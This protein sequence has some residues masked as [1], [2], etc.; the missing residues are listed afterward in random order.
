MK[1]AFR[2]LLLFP[3]G[4]PKFSNK[5]FFKGEFSQ[6]D[7]LS[8]PSNN[9]CQ[10]HFRCSTARW[11]EVGA[12]YEELKDEKNDWSWRRPD[13][14]RQLSSGLSTMERLGGRNKNILQ[15]CDHPGK[16]T[17]L[18]LPLSCQALE[19]RKGS[20]VTWHQ[21]EQCFQLY[22]S[23]RIYTTAFGGKQQSWGVLPSFTWL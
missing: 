11:K 21:W 18:W 4:A 9:P 10:E 15:H 7:F 19:Q 1:S 2:L 8:N 3:L 23:K 16:P 12:L 13:L 22:S 20:G 6:G 14:W 17:V 5:N